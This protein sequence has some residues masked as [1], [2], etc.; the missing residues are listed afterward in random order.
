[1]YQCLE[2]KGDAVEG[3][4]QMCL[5]IHI[6]ILFLF[7]S[8]VLVCHSPHLNSVKTTH[9][10]VDRCLWEL[11]QIDSNLL[12]L[13]AIAE[14]CPLRLFLSGHCKLKTKMSFWKVGFSS[15]FCIWK[16]ASPKTLSCQDCQSCIFSKQVS[17]PACSTINTTSKHPGW[18][19]GVMLKCSYAFAAMF[20]FQHVISVCSHDHFYYC[21]YYS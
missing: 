6:F 9:L 17:K 19:V 15:G 8:F 5:C 11:S 7:F 13:S 20:V 10:S 14:G 3:L 18:W 2:H 1:M 4:P 16:A 21:Y 12:L